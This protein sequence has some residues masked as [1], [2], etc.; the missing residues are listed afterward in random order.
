MSDID[1]V[2][3][4][5]LARDVPTTLQRGGRGGRNSFKEALFLIMYESWAMTIDLD[6]AAIDFTSDPDHPNVTKLSIHST[7]QQRTGGAILTIIQ[8]VEVCLRSMFAE[9]LAD[10]SLDG[11]SAVL[12]DQ[13]VQMLTL[14]SRSVYD[15]V[16]LLR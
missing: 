6:T 16:R 5:G 9:Y 7:K 11:T 14:D 10:I 13:Y 8:S 2:I 4:Y 15:T 1:V 3:Q 12:L